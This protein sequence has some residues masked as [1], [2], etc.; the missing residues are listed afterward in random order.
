MRLCPIVS[1]QRGN[2]GQV[3]K[4]IVRGYSATGAVRQLS[5]PHW[6]IFLQSGDA[7]TSHMTLNQEER[8]SPLFATID[9]SAGGS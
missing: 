6:G 3:V 9:V 1:A 5:R 7:S 2:L 8:F 4:T